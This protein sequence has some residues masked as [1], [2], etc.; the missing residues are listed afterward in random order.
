MK[1]LILPS[2]YGKDPTEAALKGLDLYRWFQAGLDIVEKKLNL[3]SK[4]SEPRCLP[5]NSTR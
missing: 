1:R 3:L 4:P 2:K 5:Y